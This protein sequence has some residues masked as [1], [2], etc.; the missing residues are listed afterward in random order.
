MLSTFSLYDLLTHDGQK[1]QYYV[2]SLLY[3]LVS[4]EAIRFLQQMKH[5]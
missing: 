2:I 5:V 4:R 1:L 3:I